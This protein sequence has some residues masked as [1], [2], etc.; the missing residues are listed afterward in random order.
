S[1]I[2]EGYQLH[3]AQ[4]IEKII[5]SLQKK[6]P[7][8]KLGGIAILCRSNNSARM[9]KEYITQYEV[10]FREDTPLDTI[11]T[12][13]SAFFS[14]C[15][16]CMFD[17]KLNVNELFDKYWDG[18]AHGSTY[19]QSLSELIKL[20][21]ETDETH[22]NK[23]RN[24]INLLK[25]V[26]ELFFPN[27]EKIYA[28]QALLEVLNSETYIQSYFPQKDSLIQL[29]TLHKSKGLE[30][31]IVFHLDIYQWTIPS[32]EALKGNQKEMIQSLNL[33]YVGITRAKQACFLITSTQKYDPQTKLVKKAT[34]S[35]FLTRPDLS[36][37]RK[38]L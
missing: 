9:I 22:F 19:K 36:K 14:E 33:H 23:L 37:I 32:Y 2:V 8:I 3:I 15:L 6:F 10:Q 17:S 1:K 18:E 7:D 21:N 34:I 20:K 11:G 29:M 38:N 27:A 25:K 28:E 35:E 26:A 16:Y 24:S 13:L 31:E 4:W 12:P 5:P 30:F